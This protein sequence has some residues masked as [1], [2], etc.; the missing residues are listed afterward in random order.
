[1]NGLE[2]CRCRVD[3]AMVRHVALILLAFVVLQHLRLHPKETLGETKDRLQREVMAK[4]WT[5]PSPL[6][7]PVAASRVLIRC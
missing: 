3:Q 1:M 5:P 4:G 6:R 7:G 2:V